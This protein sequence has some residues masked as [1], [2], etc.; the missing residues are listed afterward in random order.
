MHARKYYSEASIVSPCRL[1]T[2]YEWTAN[3][4]FYQFLDTVKK[5]LSE[6]GVFIWLLCRRSL[7]QKWN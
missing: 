3:T 6:S 2:I 1:R 7:L 4:K 5:K